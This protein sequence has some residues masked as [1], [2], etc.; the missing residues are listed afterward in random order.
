MT[1]TMGG[2][3]VGTSYNLRLHC[4]APKSNAFCHT[5]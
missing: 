4:A 3:S 2:A 5:W 1:A